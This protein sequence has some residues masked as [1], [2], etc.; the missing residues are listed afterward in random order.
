MNLRGVKKRNSEPSVIAQEQ[1]Q[2][3]SSENQTF[4]ALLILELSRDCQ[5]SVAGLGQKTPSD[6]LSDILFVNVVLLFDAWKQ[7]FDPLFLKDLLIETSLHRGSRAEQ[8]Q[9]GEFPLL[10]KITS[11]FYDAYQREW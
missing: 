2:F 11:R 7:Q 4:N 1:G 10:R 3:G 6:Q 9:L 5:Q 8:A